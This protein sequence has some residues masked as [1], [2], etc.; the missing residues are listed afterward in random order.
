MSKL[1][2]ILGLTAG[3][4]SMSSGSAQDI[5]PVTE[6]VAFAAFQ[7]GARIS[8]RMYRST[9][10]KQ[11]S[12]A[13]VHKGVSALLEDAVHIVPGSICVRN[14]TDSGAIVEAS[15]VM[16]NEPIE[17]EVNE[18]EK[19]FFP[20]PV[21][22]NYLAT[23][24]AV[25]L[26]VN[27]DTHKQYTAKRIGSRVTIARAG[28]LD[29]DAALEALLRKHLNC[30]VATACATPIMALSAAA[31][32]RVREQGTVFSYVS[33]ANDLPQLE[34]AVT[35]ANCKTPT[36]ETS[37]D[38]VLALSMTENVPPLTVPMSM[39]IDQLPPPDYAVQPTSSDVALASAKVCSNIPGLDEIMA[40]YKAYGELNQ[41]YFD[42]LKR[43]A[44]SS[45]CNIPVL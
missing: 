24:G 2:Q 45:A 12:S 15:V 33:L 1:H 34:V 9:A 11:V 43:Q 31:Y 21:A 42:E 13:S 32:E 19:S 35:V 41:G 36:G 44:A 25:N 16:K 37:K 3:A 18:F 6:L 20:V 30:A 28:E 22:N 38:Y 8:S 40:Y 4:V 10:G 27:V 7:G 5:V 14:T 17:M 29:D 39:V 26:Y 23:A